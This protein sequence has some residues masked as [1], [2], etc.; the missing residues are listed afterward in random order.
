MTILKFEEF[1]NDFILE[2]LEN[3]QNNSVDEMVVEISNIVKKNI[4]VKLDVIV[5]PYFNSKLKNED[6][7]QKFINIVYRSYIR[8]YLKVLKE[9]G[10]YYVEG[11]GVKTNKYG[12]P[13][14]NFAYNYI[15]H[16]DFEKEAT[17]YKEYDEFNRGV[18]ERQTYKYFQ[19]VWS[20]A[21]EN[22]VNR[23]KDEFGNNKF[24]LKLDHRRKNDKNND[25]DGTLIVFAPKNNKFWKAKNLPKN[26]RYN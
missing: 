22:V 15:K 12:E 16:P 2:N 3:T 19:N 9:Y 24:S 8:E 21:C 13:V 26:Q 5:E 23:Y 1:N 20:I 7:K 11:T 10:N 17:E 14:Q 18:G 6:D 4:D 25:F